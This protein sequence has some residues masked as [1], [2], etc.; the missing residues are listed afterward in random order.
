[1]FI[2]SALAPLLAL[3]LR[4]VDEHDGNVV[5]DRIHPVALGALEPGAV[6]HEADRLQAFRA[7][8]NL[9]QCRIDSQRPVSLKALVTISEV[10]GDLRHGPCRSSVKQCGV[11][12]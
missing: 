12:R 8:E 9:E 1:M 5:L 7:D 6:V 11:E 10:T 4:L 2:G 3:H